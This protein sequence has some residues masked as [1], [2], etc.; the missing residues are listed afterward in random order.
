M[1]EQDKNLF[2]V[3]HMIQVEI[4]LVS[5]IFTPKKAKIQNAK[6]GLIFGVYYIKE[7]SDVIIMM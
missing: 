2:K 4:I 5:R 7:T 6:C 1:N 3:I